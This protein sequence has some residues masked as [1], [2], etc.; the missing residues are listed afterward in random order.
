M[1]VPDVVAGTDALQPTS[2]GDFG[3]SVSGGTY[4]PAAGGSL[5]LARVNGA[6]ANGAG[7]APVYRPGGIGSGSVAFGT[8]TQIPVAADGSL[9]VVYEVVDANPSAIESAVIPTFLGLLPDGN[10]QASFTTEEVF[11][12]PSSTVGIASAS[13]PLPRF[14]PE[15][16]QPDCAIV[17]DCDPV[18]PKLSVSP[19][20]LQFTVQAGT[21][22]QTANIAIA[23]SGGGALSWKASMAY[24]SGAGWLSV[25]PGAGFG[26]S[27]LG[28][29]AIPR[30]LAPSTYTGTLTVDAGPIAGIVAIPV[31][32]TV[33][34]P[35]APPSPAISAVLNAASLL[36]E[37]VV[38]GSLTTLMGIELRPARWFQ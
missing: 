9:Y 31:T 21:P 26:N 15:I 17:G 11:F 18:P 22:F 28:T 32:M 38:P 6:S 8:V 19:G 36:A 16:A 30:S 34:A 14:V 2:A 1:Y 33:T 13:D 5:L 37:P 12:A 27:T 25:S 23:N 24:T 29:V 4:A 3:M 20:S 7:G 10:R 35:P